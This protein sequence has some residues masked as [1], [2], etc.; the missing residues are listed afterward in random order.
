[1]PEFREKL[2]KVVQAAYPY[3][4]KLCAEKTKFQKMEML[5]TV[6][7]GHMLVLDNIVETTEVDEFVYHEMMTHVPM[8][9]HPGPKRVLIIGGGDGGVLREVLR[10]PVERAVMVEIDEAVVRASKKYLK[11]I[12]RDAFKDPRAELIIGD[13]AAFVRD[14]TETFDIV[15]VDSTDP[16]GPSMP[17]FGPEFYRNVTRI[18]G[19]YGLLVRQTGS[20]LL[21]P[22]ELPMAVKHARQVFPYVKAFVTAV[23]TYIG[24][25]FTHPLMGL[26]DFSNNIRREWVERRYAEHPLPMKYY[27]PAVHAAAFALPEYIRQRVEE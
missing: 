11:K 6:G 21:Q 27:N 23:P 13:G 25:F 10:H 5:D 16:L 18:L 19:E 2:F 8:Y 3:K 12:C 1:M 9:T 20:A 7:F 24:G 17:L 15:I 4:K 26:H 22:D 14:T